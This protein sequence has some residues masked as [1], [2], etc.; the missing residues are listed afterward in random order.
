MLV[1]HFAGQC[2]KLIHWSHRGDMIAGPELD[3]VGFFTLLHVGLDRASV[4]KRPRPAF[5][6]A[7][8]S[9]PCPPWR[10]EN[11]LESKLSPS[12]L[13]LSCCLA[14]PVK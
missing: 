1:L 7:A 2:Y 12:P 4:K 10:D 3:H 11:D 13:H 9:F 6:G 8:V 14:I 5:P